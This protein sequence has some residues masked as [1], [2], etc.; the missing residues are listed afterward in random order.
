MA[1]LKVGQKVYWRG[2]W[3]NEVPKIATVQDIQRVEPGQKYGYDVMEMDWIEVQS[4]EAVVTLNN[5]HWAYG[6]QLSPIGRKKK[7]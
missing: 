2:S 1:V 6:G 4:N 7:S 5:G 3:G